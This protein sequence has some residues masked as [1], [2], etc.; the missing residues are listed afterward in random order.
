MQNFFST[1]RRSFL[2]GGGGGCLVKNMSKN[3][4]ANMAENLEKGPFGVF[5][6]TILNKGRPHSRPPLKTPLY[7]I[8]LIYNIDKVDIAKFKTS[9]C[10]ISQFLPQGIF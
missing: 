4:G 2:T 10:N 3:M 5:R 9:I 1:G 6:G 7:C 8:I